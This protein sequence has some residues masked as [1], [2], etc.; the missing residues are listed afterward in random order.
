[1]MVMWVFRLF[2][3]NLPESPTYLMSRG[4]DEDAVA[5]VHK[6]A[7]INGKISNLTVAHLKGAEVL[8]GDTKIQTDTKMV[9]STSA[10]RKFSE[11]HAGHIRPLFAT[12]VLAYSTSILIVLWALIGLATPLYY[13]FQTYYLQTRGAAHGSLS[14]AYRDQV[15]SSFLCIPA[16]LMAGYLIE[17]SII[18]R[19][20]TL[21]IFTVLTG[22]FILLSTTASTSNAFNGWNCGINYACTIMYGVLYA[23]SL[24]LFPIK[25][26]GTGYTMV[27]TVNCTCNAMASI[28]ALYANINTSLPMWVSGAVL[29]LAGFIALCLPIEPRGDASLESQEGCNRGDS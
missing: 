4:R 19:R 22:V 5:V 16:A 8:I 10:M 21:A 20:R 26:R 23:L 15:I 28:I 24:E 27:F 9:T 3:F 25:A 17:I 2:A 29:V 14:A 18:G 6:V 1:M 12:R 7:T 11:F 13:D